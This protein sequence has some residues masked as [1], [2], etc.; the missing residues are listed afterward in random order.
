[1][2]DIRLLEEQVE[3][4]RK[5]VVRLEA[6]QVVRA[7]DAPLL[8]TLVAV[9]PALQSAPHTPQ[10]VGSDFVG[11]VRDSGVLSLPR[12]VEL[13]LQYRPENTSPMHGDKSYIPAEITLRVTGIKLE[14]LIAAT[15][16]TK[17]AVQ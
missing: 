7:A 1:V 17:E 10:Y 3:R 5:E 14:Q 13:R 12:G 8:A 6:E 2:T 4:A 16:G 15:S 11:A 9:A